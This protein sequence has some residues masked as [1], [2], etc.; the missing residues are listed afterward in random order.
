MREL[1]RL[2]ALDLQTEWVPSLLSV[3][4]PHQVV[5]S[6]IQLLLLPSI[7]YRSSG[8]WIRSSLKESISQVSTGTF[9]TLT[10][11]ELFKSITMLET[12]TS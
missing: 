9:P 12:Q 8:D 6:L 1:V 3:L 11:I 4:S 10:T 2:L 5:I 7:L